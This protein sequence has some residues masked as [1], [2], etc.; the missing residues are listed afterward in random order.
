MT[1]LK[2]KHVFICLQSIYFLYLQKNKTTCLSLGER[3]TGFTRREILKETGIADSGNFSKMLDALI[4]SDFIESY[5]P[6]GEGKRN[7][8]YKLSD[9]FCMFYLKF[10]DGK[11]NIDD[12][13]WKFNVTSPAISIW[14]GFAFEEVCFRHITQIKQALGILGVITS[15]SSWSLRG[16]DDIDGTQIDMLIDRNDNVVNMCEMKFYNENFTIS[17]QYN[18]TIVHRLNVLSGMIPKRKSIHSTLIT[19]YG[20]TQNEYSGDFQQVITLDALFVES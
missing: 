17:K 18:S 9:M 16:D 10:V 20:L 8:R 4:A 1:S 12:N 5:V 6:F 11:T 2:E 13:F 14:R 7:L 3:R 19:T 15:Q